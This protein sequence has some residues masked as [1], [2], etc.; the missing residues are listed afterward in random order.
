M[1][2]SS[3]LPGPHA[4][5]LD[6]GG[7]TALVTGAAGGIGRACALR[8]AAAGAKVRAVDRDAAGLEALTERAAGLAGTVEPR[9]LDLTDLDAA[10]HAAAGTDVLVNNAGIQLVRPIEEF[11]PEVFHTV[12]TVML[13]A[14]FRLIRGALPHMYGQ[15][16]GRI[17]N[18]SSVHGLRASPYKAAYVAAK[19]GLEG[20]SKTAA[21]EGA[22]HGVTSNCVNPAYVRTPLVERQITDQSRAHGIPEERVVSEVLLQ[23]S[24]LKRL[25]EPEEVAEAVAY[26][27]GPHTA[28]VTGTSLVLDGGW[29]AH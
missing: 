10:E 7:R 29:T 1:T 25:I 19:H 15:G 16:W 9:V 12:L 28:F 20:L 26:L 14:P 6:L 4:P 18:V 3:A 23:D 17:V 5:T 11:P 22:P 8:L 13:E 2:G 21:L 24:A 27:C